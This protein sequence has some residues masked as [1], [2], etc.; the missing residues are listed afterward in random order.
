[1]IRSFNL[2]LLCKYISC[3]RYVLSPFFSVYWSRWGGKRYRK[4]RIFIFF[5]AS[6]YIFK[7]AILVINLCIYHYETTFSTISAVIEVENDNVNGIA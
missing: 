2:L 6:T 1:M 4:K 7:C 5:Y 3:E